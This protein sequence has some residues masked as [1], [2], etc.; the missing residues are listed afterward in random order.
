MTAVLGFTANDC[1]GSPVS[2]DYSDQAPLAFNGKVNTTRNTYPKSK[3]QITGETRPLT[4]LATMRQ[5]W[6]SPIA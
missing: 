3:K 4:R 2:L 6:D 5:E 1:L